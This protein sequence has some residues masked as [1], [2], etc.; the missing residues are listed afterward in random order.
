MEPLGGQVIE[1]GAF[2]NQWAAV[3][4]YV[5]VIDPSAIE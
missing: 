5:P 3:S 1:G 2:A 4:K